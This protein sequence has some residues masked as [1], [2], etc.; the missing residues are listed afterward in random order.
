MGRGQSGLGGRLARWNELHLEAKWIPQWKSHK[1]QG[2][3]RPQAMMGETLGGSGG[4]GWQSGFHC[5]RARWLPTQSRKSHKL[6]GV[7]GWRPSRDGIWQSF[8]Q[9]RRPKLWL[10]EALQENTAQ[11]QHVKGSLSFHEEVW[12]ICGPRLTFI[13]HWRAK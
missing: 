5:H 13:I 9:R 6:S 2:E 10:A 7:S 12:K 3:V 11:I 4:V 1:R 8:A